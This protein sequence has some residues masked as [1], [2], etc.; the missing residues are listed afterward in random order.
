MERQLATITKTFTFDSS[1]YL[2]NPEYTREENITM[3]H[4]CCFYKEDGANEPHG[5]TYHLEV[6]VTG[7]VSEINGY[8]IDFKDLK[9]ILEEGVLEKLDHRSIND[10]PWFKDNFTLTTVENI[11]HY[12]WKE[13]QPQID[14]LRPGNAWLCKIKMYETPT[15]YATLDRHQWE[16]EQQLQR[17]PGKLTTLAKKCTD[18]NCLCNSKGNV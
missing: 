1:H 10:I 8:I 18:S 17:G 9:S 14:S 4:K 11:L 13:I 2:L 5:H 15:S 6:Y 16:V 7:F 12:V 3:F